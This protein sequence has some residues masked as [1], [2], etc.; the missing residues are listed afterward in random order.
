MST[1]GHGQNAANAEGRG[2]LLAPRRQYQDQ[3]PA[4]LA[5]QTLTRPPPSVTLNSMGMD[6]RKSLHPY[7]A[8]H[9][10]T[11]TLAEM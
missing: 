6:S 10:H 9:A 1:A 7:G 2:G 3:A 5:Q 4:P 11:H 8:T